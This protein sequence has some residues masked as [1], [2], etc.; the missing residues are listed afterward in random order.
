MRG[1]AQVIE[2]LTQPLA[3]LGMDLAR[4]DGAV[5]AA[6]NGEDERQLLQVRIDR[7]LHVRVLQLHGERL[8]R[9]RSRAMHLSERG[10]R[11]RFA[12]ET[13]EALLPVRSELGTHAPLHEG[14]AHRRRGGLKLGQFGGKF[15]RH[16]FRHGR[17]HL[18]DLHDRPLETAKGRLEFLCRAAIHLIEAEKTRPRRP[19]RDAPDTGAH[20]RIALHATA[21]PVRLAV[22]RALAGWRRVVA[23]SIASSSSMKPRIM[24]RPL[25]QKAGSLASS[26]NGASS[27]LWRSVPPADS[28]S[29]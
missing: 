8:A 14:P 23:H 22:A 2:F 28:I 20:L 17:D 16:H 24:E 13:S 19:R 1:L 18:R 29:K 12:L 10:G 11:R 3:D 4:I 5:H 21:K 6:M 9:E 27:S 15:R 26:P 7:R 25:S